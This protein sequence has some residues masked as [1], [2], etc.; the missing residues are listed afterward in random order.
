MLVVQ[1]QYSLLD[2]RPDNG[3]AAFAQLHNMA[4]LPYGVVAGGF[5]CEKYLGVSARDVDVNTYSKGKYA[6]VL[7]QAGGWSWL[8]QLLQVSLGP[9]TDGLQWDDAG[10]GWL[11]VGSIW[12]MHVRE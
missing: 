4:L 11:A 9:S 10:Q 2:R 1:V 8:Q 7:G 3:M 12:V 6:S 5:L